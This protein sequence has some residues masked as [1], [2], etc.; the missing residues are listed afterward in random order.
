MS[1]EDLLAAHVGLRDRLFDAGLLIPS[2]VDGLYGRSSDFEKVVAGLKQAVGS[3]G[4]PDGPIEVEFPPMLPRAT[5]DRIGYMRN[6][7]Q[8]CGPVFSF[9]GGEREFASLLHSLD[10]GEPYDHHL[11]QADVALTPACC[12][13][14]YPTLSGRVLQTAVVFQTAQYCFRH[15]PSQDPMRLQAFRQIENIVIGPPDEVL[16]WREGW[17][18]RA[19]ALLGDLGLEVRSDVASDQF[20]GRAGRLMSMS[21]REQQLKIEF[22][23]PVFG[24][25]APTACASINYHQDHF[26]ELFG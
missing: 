4:R 11:S 9:R 3:L 14:V 13:P 17:L 25:E 5:F 21:Q 19:P 16:D 26:G 1:P 23:V 2:G 15:E 22:L 20:F 12:Y 8:L 24:E 10:A 6:F 18:E 7:P